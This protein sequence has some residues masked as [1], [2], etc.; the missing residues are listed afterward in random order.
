MTEAE[1]KAAV[2]ARARALAA[3]CLDEQQ[4]VAFYSGEASEEQAEAIRD[5]LAECGRC[6]ELARDAREFLEDAREGPAV[7]PMPV[8]I[9]QVSL[10]PPKPAPPRARPLLAAAAAV[11]LGVGLWWAQKTPPAPA[12]PP[13][14]TV[15]PP[16]HTFGDLPVAKA[17]YVRPRG[18]GDDIVWRGDE[19]PTEAP[20]DAFSRAMLLYERDDFAGAERRLALVTPRDARHAEASFYRGVSLLLLGRASDAI[21]PL[22]VA[23]RLGRGA[24]RQDALWYLALARLKSGDTKAA[25]AALE[26]VAGAPCPHRAEAERLRRQVLAAVTP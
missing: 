23:S 4:L 3:P 26:A 8:A 15:A 5:H 16:V 1:W 10:V 7:A 22:E 20:R 2:Q 12:P 14:P 17:P 25:V 24:E 21:A 9:T 13:A 19:P 11:V 18:A 6:L